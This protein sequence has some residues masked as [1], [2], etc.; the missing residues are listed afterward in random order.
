MNDIVTNDLSKYGFRELSLAGELLKAYGDNGANFLTDG[1]TLNFNTN[2]GIVFLCDEDM[3]VGVLENAGEN[4]DSIMNKVVQ[5]YSCPQCGNEGTQ[6]DGLENGWDFEKFD[7]Y[8]TKE[9]V[10]KSND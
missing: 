4:E 2:S 9:C 7:D 3:N 5:F 1:I 10:K 8:C 6:K